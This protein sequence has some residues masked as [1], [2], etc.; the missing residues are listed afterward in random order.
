[1]P[2]ITDIATAKASE[3][4]SAAP[5]RRRRIPTAGSPAG[6]AIRNRPNPARCTSRLA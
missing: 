1:V 5:S 3:R 4:A 6:T 2:E